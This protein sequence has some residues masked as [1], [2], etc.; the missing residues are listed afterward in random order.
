VPATL[1]VQGPMVQY[2]DR[3]FLQALALGAAV[4]DA[5]SVMN[6]TQPID[7]QAS[8][9]YRLTGGALPTGLSLDPATGRISGTA[10]AGGAFTATVQ[11]SLATQ[12]GTFTPVVSTYMVNVNVPFVGYTGGASDPLHSGAQTVYISQPATL[13]PVLIGA[14]APGTT[15][16][17]VSVQ[18]TLPPGLTLDAA[19][20]IISGTPGAPGQGATTYDVQATLTNGSASAST[21]GRLELAVSPPVTYTY[22]SGVTLPVNQPASLAPMVTAVSAVPLSGAATV[23]YQP[24]AGSCTLPPGMAVDA[25]SGAIAGTPTATGSFQCTVDVT[26]TD[27]GVTWTSASSA[28]FLVQ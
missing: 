5:P 28:A 14:S 15:V 21:Q 11:A 27:H 25:S 19:T 9:S 23:S 8:W 18:G 20:G 17:N 6:W 10:Q 26:V 13:T 4:V 3:S 12:F 7:L 16:S 2:P 22:A 1:R 24:D